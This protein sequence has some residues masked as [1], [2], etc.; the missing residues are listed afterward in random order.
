MRFACLI[1]VL[2][3]IGVIA[4]PVIAY[5]HGGATPVRIAVA[6]ILVL[7]PGLFMGMA[8]PIAMKMAEARRPSLM[9]WLWG[10]NGA[11]SICAA[12]LA[13]VIS[14]SQGISVAWWT[15]V[16]TYIVAALLILKDARKPV[17]LVATV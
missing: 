14:S 4:P 15:G 10:I 7:A 6:L 17:A 2:A 5:F 8:F 13:V 3:V 1:G 9:A 11:A 16:A 12:V